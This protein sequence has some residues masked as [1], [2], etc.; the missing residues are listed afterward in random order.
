MLLRLPPL[1]SSSSPR[2]FVA[3]SRFG[4]DLP[5]S[6]VVPGSDK[7][8]QVVRKL[9]QM[10]V[11][12][13]VV[14][15]VAADVPPPNYRYYGPRGPPPSH[16]KRP[17]RLP[18]RPPHGP[19]KF[20]P[21]PVHLGR[22]PSVNRPFKVAPPS[23]PK[24]A[25]VKQ[26]S[27]SPPAGPAAH[28]VAPIVTS[29]EGAIH[30]IPAPNLGPNSGYVSAPPA[31]V[32]SVATPVVPLNS[33]DHGYEVFEDPSKNSFGLPYYAPDPDPSRPAPHVPVT[34]DPNS[35]PSVSRSPLDRLILQQFEASVPHSIKVSPP[36]S[37][38]AQLQAAVQNT[39]TFYGDTNS[40]FLQAFQDQY[41]KYKGFDQSASKLKNDIDYDSGAEV[42]Y[43]FA[44]APASH[45]Q[46][47]AASEFYDD[48]TEEQKSDE[49]LEDSDADFGARLKSKRNH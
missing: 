38:M 36:Q 15:C 26:F 3:F 28:Y 45:D 41:E 9:C 20:R 19:P 29:N 4:S 10:F 43:S 49:I 8:T 2:P 16:L 46:D 27:P 18:P 47:D 5:C 1:L 25:P 40:R 35:H 22:A 44:P 12:L 13:V 48:E 17:L 30:T 31:L 39:T 42:R 33:V 14:A 37:Q 24:V 21:L 34:R 11:L 32:S 23:R 7:M 6:Q